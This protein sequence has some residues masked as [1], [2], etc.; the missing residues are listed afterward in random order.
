MKP[1]NVSASGGAVR[2]RMRG[3]DFNLDHD[4][5]GGSSM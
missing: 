5:A 1:V 4:F 2:G 3:G